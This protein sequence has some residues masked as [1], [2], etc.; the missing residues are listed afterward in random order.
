MCLRQKSG[1][2][3]VDRW[4]CCVAS[5]TISYVVA[6]ADMDLAA[7]QRVQAEDGLPMVI[8][9]L[10]EKYTCLRFTELITHLKKIRS[11]S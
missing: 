7:E 4:G 6:Q 3:G 11:K 5:Q 9:S 10:Y 2:T 8:L 1:Q